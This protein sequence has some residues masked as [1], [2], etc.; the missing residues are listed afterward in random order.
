MK[1]VQVCLVLL[2]CVLPGIGCGDA[3]KAKTEAAVNHF[4]AA[5]K[6]IAEGDNEAA[7]R[8]LTASIEEK[9]SAW[10][11]FQRA[12]VFLDDGKEKE[13]AEDC[14]KGLESDP[15]HRDLKWLQGE[16]KKPAAKR[17]KGRFK[18]PPSAGK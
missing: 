14:V 3:E 15:K 10:A 11:Y 8:E 6:A 18:N 9:P 2:A 5:A 13:A 17:F 7:L 4:V 1:Q 16:L 12:K